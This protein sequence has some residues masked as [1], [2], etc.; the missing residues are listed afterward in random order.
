MEAFFQQL[1]R[2]VAAAMGAFY[3]ALGVFLMLTDREF[4]RL[5]TTLRI[6]LGGLLVLYGIYRVTR[7]LRKSHA[8]A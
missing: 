3:V 4:L 8:G 7:S 1:L 6:L 2:F 5:D